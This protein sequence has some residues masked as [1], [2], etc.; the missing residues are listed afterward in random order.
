L[1]QQV[2]SEPAVTIIATLF[3]LSYTPYLFICREVSLYK[4]VEVTRIEPMEWRIQIQSGQ[5]S[6]TVSKTGGKKRKKK[7]PQKF[8][9]KTIY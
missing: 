5:Y 2:Y 9:Q 4:I 3:F 1:W 6:K 7:N 8:D